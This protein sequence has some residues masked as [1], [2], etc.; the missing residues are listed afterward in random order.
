MSA[1]TSGPDI[2]T[3]PHRYPS[4]A[5]R[6]LTAIAHGSADRTV[7]CDPVRATGEIKLTSHKTNAA[8]AGTDRLSSSRTGIV[9]TSAAT[10]AAASGASTS[11]QRGGSGATE[12]S[13]QHA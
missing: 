7:D 2:D 13:V 3:V 12:G 5:T 11:N 1:P 9:S 6:A 4:H 8:D 10:T